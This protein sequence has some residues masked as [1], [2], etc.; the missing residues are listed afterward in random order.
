[1]IVL[2]SSKPQF[3][4][5]KHITIGNFFNYPYN[6]TINKKKTYNC[7][8]SPIRNRNNSPLIIDKKPS[9]RFRQRQRLIPRFTRR[10]TGLLKLITLLLTSLKPLLKPSSRTPIFSLILHRFLAIIVRRLAFLH[11]STL[12]LLLLLLLCSKAYKEV[13]GRG[14]FRV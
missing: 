7:G 4:I 8:N 2:A 5:P 10:R 3:A 14:F 9:R 6:K 13:F 11:R 12:L 1:M